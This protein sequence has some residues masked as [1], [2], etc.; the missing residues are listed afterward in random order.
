MYGLKTHVL[1]EQK[2]KKC[3]VFASSRSPWD[4]AEFQSEAALVA[5]MLQGEEFGGFDFEEE[6]SRWWQVFW[7]RLQRY[8]VIYK[9]YK[10]LWNICSN[11]K[12][13]LYLYIAAVD[14]YCNDV[15]CIEDASVSYDY[16][17]IS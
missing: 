1:F 12:D 9:A 17:D 16:K 6:L 8:I 14:Y 10:Y 7:V 13:I 2:F 11:C 5:E 15:L 3:K 4:C